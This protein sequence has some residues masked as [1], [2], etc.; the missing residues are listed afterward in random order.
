MRYDIRL[1]WVEDMPKWYNEAKEIIEM[2]IEDE[3]LTAQID[4]ISNAQDLLDMLE[5]ESTGFRLYDIFFIDYSL[6]Y[7]IVGSNIIKELRKIN[8][9]SDI[10]FYSSDKE[11]E[12]RKEITDD[13]GS[14]EGV[15]IANRDNFRDKSLF[16]IKKNSRKLL[17]LSNVRGLLTDQTSENDY[18]II[19]YLYKK[20]DKLSEHQKIEIE[21]MISIYMENKQIEYENKSKKE[22]EKI[23]QNGVQN[24][25]KFLKLP[26]Y[27]VPLDLKYKIFE[28]IM[29]FNNED[30]FDKYTIENYINKIVKLRNTIAHK[31]LDICRTQENIL[32]YDNINQFYRQMCPDKCEENTNKNTISV[33]QWMDIRKEV[34]EYGNCFETILQSIMYEEIEEVASSIEE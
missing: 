16:L 31:K 30:T 27:V 12:I 4:Y 34:I 25:N 1:L 29:Q 20:Y 15:Y 9:D 6:S 17:S 11:A 22:I 21:N 23:K 5:R 24:I 10:L 14:F 2:D 32:Y 3:S 8:I 18:I 33:K 28:M 19:S 26:S 13:L 7:G